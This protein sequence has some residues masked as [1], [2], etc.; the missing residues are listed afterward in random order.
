[1]HGVLVFLTPYIKKIAPYV[2][3]IFPISALFNFCCFFGVWGVVGVGM[4]LCQVDLN[5]ETDAM[6]YQIEL[7]LV[8]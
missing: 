8:L 4:V 6:Q 7:H 1:M 5:A 2:A 3:S